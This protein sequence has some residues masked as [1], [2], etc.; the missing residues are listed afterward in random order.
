[1][2][3][4]I[5]NAARSCIEMLYHF[6]SWSTYWNLILKYIYIY[7]YIYHQTLM[8][9]R[10]LLSFVNTLTLYLH[11]TSTHNLKDLAGTRGKPKIEKNSNQQMFRLKRI[12]HLQI[13]TVIYYY[14]YTYTY[15]TLVNENRFFTSAFCWIDQKKSFQIAIKVLNFIKPFS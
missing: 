12:Y 15:I 3:K 5:I 1:M 6:L 11:L 10:L 7:I 13:I 4:T 9:L 14:L 2:I 8:W